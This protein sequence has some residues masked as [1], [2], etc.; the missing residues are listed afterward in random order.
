MI[1]NDIWQRQQFVADKT[2]TVCGFCATNVLQLAETSAESKLRQLYISPREKC[3]GCGVP[4][5][6]KAEVDAIAEQMGRPRWLD[7]CSDC[8]II[9]LEDLR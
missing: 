5:V 4:T 8:R 3:P 7:Y 1:D 6:S 9:F 2:C